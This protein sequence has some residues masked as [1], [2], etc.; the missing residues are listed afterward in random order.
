MEEGVRPWGGYEVLIDDPHYKVK[1]ITVMAGQRLS[2]QR[3]A[4]RSEHWFIVEG[5]GR[6][7]IDG[8]DRLVTLGHAVD[9]AVG[10]AHRIANPAAQPLVF[11]E[12]QHGVSFEE[13]DIVR[14]DDDY[15]RSGSA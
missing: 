13:D 4:L 10:A 2:Y 1:R 15:G 8:T 6:V 3:H 7:T 5:T 11:I 9:V 12:V 14:L